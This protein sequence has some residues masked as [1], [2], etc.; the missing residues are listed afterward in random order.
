MTI[1]DLAAA[2]SVNNEINL[3]MLGL[4]KDDQFELKPGKGKTIRSNFVHIVSVRAQWV[5]EK[6]PQEAAAIPKL[7]WRSATRD[8][9][10]SGLTITC[11]LMEQRFRKLDDSAKPGKQT[12]LNLFAYC[13]AHEGNHRAQIEI[14][15]R[16]N[17]HEPD[18]KA[19]YRLWEWNRK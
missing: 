8:E 9:I 17:G 6:M 7:D 16:I 10:I 13:I 18:D 1:E 3:E 11:T 19:L 12:A 14:A 5:S 4:C 2:W 15:L